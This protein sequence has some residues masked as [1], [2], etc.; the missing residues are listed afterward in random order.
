MTAFDVACHSWG[1]YSVLNCGGVTSEGLR[2]ARLSISLKRV[3][4]PRNLKANVRRYDACS[5]LSCPSAFARNNRAS[6]TSNTSAGASSYRIP[7]S[8]LVRSRSEGGRGATGRAGLSPCLLKWYCCSPDGL[9]TTGTSRRRPAIA[10]P[11]EHSQ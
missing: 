3:E 2:I 9:N 1:D 5:R 4:V 10:S 6:A 7:Y 11:P 8:L